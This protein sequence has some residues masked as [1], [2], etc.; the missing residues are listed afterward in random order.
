MA[1]AA[2]SLWLEKVYRR[3]ALLGLEARV[4]D[5]FEPLVRGVVEA[6]PIAP[7][8]V[9]TPEDEALLRAAIGIV[10]AASLLGAEFVEALADVADE[11][12]EELMREEVE[13]A[14]TSAKLVM[15]HLRDAVRAYAVS[16]RAV[17]LRL[18]WANV[19]DW[20][21]FVPDGEQEA[22]DQLPEDG[23]QYLRGMAALVIATT[24]L[25]Q[26]PDRAGEW[27]GWAQL[28]SRSARRFEASMHVLL[29]RLDAELPELRAKL[30][31]KG[32]TEE[33]VAKE[34]APWPD[35]SSP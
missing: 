16:G 28:A 22:V 24:L 12:F 13:A 9:G 7:P 10:R 25:R 29:A 32:W 3:S 6:A 31:W 15:H 35:E 23:R 4:R 18:R 2:Q 26:A 17:A 30:A 1:E 11:E 19:S 27:A 33:D 34:F 8:D 5:E 14:D 20:A 21:D